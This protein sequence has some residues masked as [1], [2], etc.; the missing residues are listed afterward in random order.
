MKKSKFTESQIVA[1]LKE[2]ES[3]VPVASIHKV[4][5][6]LAEAAKTQA[7]RDATIAHPGG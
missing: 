3:G 4:H 5:F 1:I 6:R 7:S 2:G